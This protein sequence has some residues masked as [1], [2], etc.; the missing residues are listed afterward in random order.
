LHG[1]RGVLLEQIRI[2]EEDVDTSRYQLACLY[3]KAGIPDKALEN[4]E[5]AYEE[6]NFQ[7]SVIQVDPDLDA[8]RP[9]PRFIGLVNRVE[10][11]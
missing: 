1:W 10:G 5:K 8:L 2:A 4:L 6:R 11:K 9:D 3:A 7:I